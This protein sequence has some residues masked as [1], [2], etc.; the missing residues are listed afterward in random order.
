MTINELV[1]HLN[2]DG[3]EFSDWDDHINETDW[4]AGDGCVGHTDTVVTRDDEAYVVASID[5]RW[6]HFPAY[7]CIDDRYDP[8][9]GTPYLDASV[10]REMVADSF[11]EEADAA[12]MENGSTVYD[13]DGTPILVEWSA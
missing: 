1:D 10:F 7:R 8:D 13:P 4:T 11:G 2:A 6:Q 5:G 9:G 12:L 3:Y